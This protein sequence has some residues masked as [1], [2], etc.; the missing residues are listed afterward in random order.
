MSLRP[1]SRAIRT[2]FVHFCTNRSD[3]VSAAV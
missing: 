1:V 2:D 3:R